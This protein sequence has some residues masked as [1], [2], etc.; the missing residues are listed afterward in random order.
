MSGHSSTE[1]SGDPAHVPAHGPGNFDFEGWR[2][3]AADDPAAYFDARRWAIDAFIAAA[4]DRS[5][6][7]RHRK[8]QLDAM[9]DLAGSRMQAVG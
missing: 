3:L 5:D 2:K 9:S 7:L 1:K 8:N 4:P 6:E